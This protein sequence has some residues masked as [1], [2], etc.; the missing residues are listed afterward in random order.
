M[1]QECRRP[2]R[3]RRCGP[4]PGPV[5]EARLGRGGAATAL[6]QTAHAAAGGSDSSALQNGGSATAVPGRSA[7]RRSGGSG[8]SGLHHL[9]A[10]F[11]ANNLAN[12]PVVWASTACAAFV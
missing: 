10:G 8:R 11:S 3:G 9:A 1:P 6:V 4:M 12:A 2:A 5:N 7:P